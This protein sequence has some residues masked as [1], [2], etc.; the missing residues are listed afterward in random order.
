MTQWIKP[1]ARS[2]CIIGMLLATLMGCD[3]GSDGGTGQESVFDNVQLPPEDVDDSKLPP[4]AVVGTV[5]VVAGTEPKTPPQ[6]D[7]GKALPSDK[8]TVKT[9]DDAILLDEDDNDGVPEKVGRFTEV[10]PDT[11]GGATFQTTPALEYDLGNLVALASDDYVG[12]RT[13]ECLSHRSK[14]GRAFRTLR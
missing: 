7:D 12:L 14:V 13:A 9:P 2:T 10:A 8:G 11:I 3:V 5:T 6:T 1:R 4:E